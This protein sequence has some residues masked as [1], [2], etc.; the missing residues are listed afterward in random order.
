MIEVVAVN[1]ITEVI[2]AATFE[3]IDELG[4]SNVVIVEVTVDVSAIV[5]LANAFAVMGA[6][7]YS[8][9][10]TGDVVEKFIATVVDDVKFEDDIVVDFTSVEVVSLIVRSF[11]VA[12]VVSATVN[13][14][15]PIV[16]TVVDNE[17]VSDS[18]SV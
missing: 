5:V 11:F 1:G 7:A 8:Y 6:S 4:L 16:I 17:I 18:V 3:V 9:V 10:A 15:V 12:G 13:V 2:S 14:E